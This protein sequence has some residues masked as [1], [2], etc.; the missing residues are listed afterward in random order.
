MNSWNWPG[1]REQGWWTQYEDLKLDPYLGLE[2]V[3]TS[4]TS[5]TTFYMPALLQ[6]EEYAREIIRKIAPKM[7]PDIYRQRVEVRMRRQEVLES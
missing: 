4:I 7:D 6:T 2:Q 1:A 3:A 5:F